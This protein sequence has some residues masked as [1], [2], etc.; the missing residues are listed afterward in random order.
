MK[1]RLKIKRG[2]AW[3]K[4]QIA[5]IADLI[6]SYKTVGIA[7]VRGIRAS[8][9]QRLR[10]ELRDNARLRVSKNSLIAISFK[11]SG[12]DE[13]TDYIEDQMALIFT[14]LGAFELYRLTEASKIPAPI[15]AGA[16]AP[17]DI[18]IE[19][20]PTA[21]KPGPVVGELQNLGIPAGIAGGKVEI[22]KRTV[23]VKEGE[24]VTPEI[25]EILAKLGIYPVKEGLDLAAV[26]ER[27]SGVLFKPEVLCI[28]PSEYISELCEAAK[29]ALSLATHLKY[30]Y[31]TSF[32]IGD[33]LREASIK[34]QALAFHIAY[35]TP[36]TIKPLLQKAHAAA[37]N[38][39]LNACIYNKET[40]PYLL[41]K[42]QAEA[43][44]VARRVSTGSG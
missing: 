5:L 35:P 10:R 23:V 14:N 2:K 16:V 18:V 1:K 30:A 43:E 9:L 26:Y 4:E 42:A 6:K 8:Q 41:T 31:P 21:L 13:M 38:L 15:K 28:E 7:K 24:R 19:A 27:E 3:R 22:K 44:A 17:H 33:L 34:S 36:Q 11:D 20:G 37:M 40:I 25:A 32:T 39:G 12:I 29:R